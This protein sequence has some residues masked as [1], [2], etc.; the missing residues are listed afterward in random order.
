[1][2]TGPLFKA[3]TQIGNVLSCMA[4]PRN[5]CKHQRSGPGK[6]SLVPWFSSLALVH[7]PEETALRDLAY[8]GGEK[9][10]G[11]AGKAPSSGRGSTHIHRVLHGF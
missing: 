1:M 5:Q 3:L 4:W 2:T 7:I 8:T 6:R 11:G 9:A 10:R